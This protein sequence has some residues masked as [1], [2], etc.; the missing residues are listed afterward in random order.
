MLTMFHPGLMWKRFQG[1]GRDKE[2]QAQI[3][4]P[5]LLETTYDE[6]QLKR[7]PSVTNLQNTNHRHNLPPPQSPWVPPFHLAGNLTV[8]ST[9]SLF[10]PQDYPDY[11]DSSI[12]S[13]SSVYSR[14]SNDLYYYDNPAVTPPCAYE[15]VSPPSS[16]EP[17][18]QQNFRQPRR[19]RSMRDVS[20][21][22]ENRQKFQTAGAS[23][24][25][26]NMPVLRRAPDSVQAGES[27]STQKFWGVKLA[28]NSK[29][30]WDAYSGE[31]TSGDT[32]KVQSVTPGMYKGADSTDNRPMGYHVSITGPE[33]KKN[34]SLVG[35]M[36][37]LR[38]KMPPVV[39][40][41][42]PR[43]PWSRTTGRSE[44]VPALKDEPLRKV[45]QQPRKTEALDLDK[46][47]QTVPNT[48]ATPVACVP[49]AADTA[50][51]IDSA[52]D[53]DVHQNTFKPIAPLKISKNT[54][55]SSLA[56]PTSPTNIGLGIQ[57]PYSYYS[58]V[59]P[60]QTQPSLPSTVV[61]EPKEIKTQSREQ[62]M[63]P[64]PSTV[65]KQPLEPT[66]EK[67][68][69]PLNSRFSWT[70]YNSTTTYQHSPPTTPQSG[71]STYTQVQRPRVA[72]EP[73]STASSILGRR[74]PVPQAGQ[75]P[76]PTPQATRK[77]TPVPSTTPDAAKL[78]ALSPPSS[79]STLNTKTNKALPQ[80]PTT[81]SAS[82]HISLLESQLEDLR[83][84]RTNVYRLL[85]DLNKAAPANPLVTD[86]K[87]ARLVEQRKRGYEDEL[88]EIKAEEHDIGMKLHRAWKK[89]ER[90]DPNQGSALWIRRVTS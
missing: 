71:M 64:S 22:D 23:Y 17:E 41:S 45:F 53:F 18:Q 82:D 11:R 63:K 25:V 59:T 13:V 52:H 43:E 56:S 27:Q 35:R 9:C 3:G 67:E 84:R 60:T 19:Y 62:N 6:E 50:P 38:V 70:T 66:P 31:P 37:S 1:Y 51:A 86:F 16:P 29:V 42:K 57:T 68:T 80:P 4:N 78:R 87:R 47:G 21:M 49:V 72:T 46:M 90:E 55:S 33:V 83:V 75:L 58:P 2:K 8:D 61:N 76:D 15:D 7:N 32:G 85:N 88:S 14:P 48:S 65:V 12:P 39:E 89:R 26:T 20:P 5:V 40:A 30:K 24:D 74:R 44:I 81:L 54:V 79:D 73:I 10:A 69:E 28:P 77:P 36:G 34:V